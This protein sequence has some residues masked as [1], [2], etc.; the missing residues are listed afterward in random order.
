VAQ[1]LDLLGRVLLRQPL[2]P[3]SAPTPLTIS[4][5][6]PGCYLVRVRTAEGRLTMPLLVR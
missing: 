1:V 4:A 2:D 6:V 3:S 5:L